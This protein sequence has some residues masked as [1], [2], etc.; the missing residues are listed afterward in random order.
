MRKLQLVPLSGESVDQKV[1]AF[2]QY[3]DEVMRIIY[4]VLLS[5][6][7]KITL[8]LIHA[9]FLYFTDSTLSPRHTSSDYD[10]FIQQIQG[11]KVRGE[12]KVTTETSGSIVATT[13]GGGWF[14]P[15]SAS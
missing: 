9:V 2:R 13:V 14:K 15:Q 1:S 3:T 7:P 4:F 6:L 8:D 5:W 11:K 10:N 12:Y